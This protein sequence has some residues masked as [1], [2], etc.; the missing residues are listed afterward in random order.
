MK[1][2][3]SETIGNG[4]DAIKM[5]DAQSSIMF[6]IQET[7]ESNKNSKALMM[8]STYHIHMRVGVSGSRKKKNP[9]CQSHSWPSQP[10]APS[11]TYILYTICV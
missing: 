10:A 2:G 3:I 4:G 8:L 9:L 6:G 1:F 7:G 5:D 11:G